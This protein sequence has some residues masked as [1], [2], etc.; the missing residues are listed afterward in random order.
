MQHHASYEQY[1]RGD[2]PHDHVVVTPTPAPTT[3]G[4]TAVL[5]PAAGVVDRKE[6]IYHCLEDSGKD[7]IIAILLISYALC[8]T[9]ALLLLLQRRLR[10]TWSPSRGITGRYW[11]ENPN[12]SAINERNVGVTDSTATPPT[13][14]HA[15][16]LSESPTTTST[17]SASTLRLLLRNNQ[18]RGKG[19]ETA[20]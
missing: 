4:L 18:Q 16:P 8:V 12:G 7:I 13:Q 19:V 5:E 6:R 11:R 2:V 14:R 10:R 17:E 15:T 9:A 1:P 3:T 20:V